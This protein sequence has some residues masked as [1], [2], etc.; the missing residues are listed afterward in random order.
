[1]TA[2]LLLGL[3]MAAQGVVA[4]TLFL[5]DGTDAASWH[6]VPSEGVGLELGSEGGELRLDFDFRGGSGWAAAWRPLELEL[7]ENFAL[8]IALRGE[9]PAN[10]LEV[11][12]V[13]AGDEGETVWWA[14]RQAFDPPRDATVLELK[15]RH[16]SFAWGAERGGCS[17]AA[18][19]S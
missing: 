5:D 2:S 6:A 17:T 15:R 16:F 14:R 3:L 9:A 19:P 8:R 4:P 12:L 10:T 13:M 18:R 1:M 7:P 11:K